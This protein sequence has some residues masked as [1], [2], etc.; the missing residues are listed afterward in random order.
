MSFHYLQSLLYQHDV[1]DDV[2]ASTVRRRFRINKSPT[3]FNRKHFSAHT[4]SI[5]VALPLS[6]ICTISSENH[7]YY[8]SLIYRVLPL[9]LLRHG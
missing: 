6:V 1:I 9:L 8:H 5:A 4:A 7:H 2:V 3:V